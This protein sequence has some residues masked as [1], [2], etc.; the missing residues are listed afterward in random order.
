MELASFQLMFTKPGPVGAVDV[1]SNRGD[2]T[3]TNTL[4]AYDASNSIVGT[5]SAPGGAVATLTINSTSEQHQVPRLNTPK[6]P[7]PTQ[8]RPQ[9]TRQ[10]VR[11][12]TIGAV[13]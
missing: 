1:E 12:S 7:T 5:A 8:I 6:P 3:L 9:H 11:Q 4:T 13:P 2:D 10:K